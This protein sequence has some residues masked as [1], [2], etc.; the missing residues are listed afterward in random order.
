MLLV[1]QVSETLTGCMITFSELEETLTDLRTKGKC[2][3]S[4]ALFGPER[5]A[6]LQ[7]SA[8]GCRII[9]PL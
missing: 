9:K 1:E 6:K 4:T 5:K 2:T 7:E 3:P 8:R